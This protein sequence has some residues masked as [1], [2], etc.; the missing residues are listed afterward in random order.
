[1]IL[2]SI[3]LLMTIC[4]GRNWQHFGISY[5]VVVSLVSL[6][7][8]VSGMQTNQGIIFAI[9]AVAFIVFPFM[10]FLAY[11]HRVVRQVK[12]L[13]SSAQKSNAIVD[14]LFPSDIRDKLFQQLVMHNNVD[15]KS[16]TQI[17]ELHPDTTV[18][19]AGR[20]QVNF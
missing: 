7:L 19:F 9:S 1:M 4:G 11:E 8:C 15:S 10:V 5:D 18:V 17:A 13:I 12:M 2:Y 16:G 14:S 20:F 3:F 6:S